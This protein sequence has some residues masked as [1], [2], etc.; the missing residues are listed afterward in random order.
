[1]SKKALFIGFVWPEPETTAAGRRMLQ[2]LTSFKESCYE[3]VFA[4]TAQHTAYSA[5]LADLEIKTVQIQLNQSSF[6]DFIKNLKP[7]IV[8]FDR[9]MIE[10]QFGWRVAEF[11]P[12]ALRIL[13]TEDL[14][15]LRNTREACHK[16]GEEFTTEKWL[17]S[18]ITKRE[19]ASIYRS[20]LTLII[21]PAETKLLKSVFSIP[22]DILFTLPFMLEESLKEPPTFE[23]R[24]DFI[25]I[26]NGKHAPNVD[27]IKY[28]NE[29]IWPA[30]RNELPNSKLNVYGAYLPQQINQMHDPSTGFLVHGWLK[31]LDKTL[32]NTRVNLA[33]LRFGAGLKGKVIDGIRNGTPT[34]TT[35]IGAEG[36]PDVGISYDNALEFAQKAIGIYTNKEEWL[37]MQQLGFK[38]LSI[39][40]SKEQLAPTLFS[41][42]DILKNKLQEHRNKNFIGSLLQ[43]QTMASTKYMSKW[44]AEKNKKK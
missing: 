30:I 44:I 10:E 39:Y 19:L 3:V 7:T 42:I 38:I 9:F 2:L 36:I 31:D 1:M 32:Q 16:K 34:I 26:G 18:D 17:E 20:D 8:I 24:K 43:H 41:K 22:E 35:A 4:S 25:F 6:D 14:H 15:S 21:S 28:L 40:F 27:A 12:Q 5:N 33:P 29:S 37:K 13:N 23:A 11:A